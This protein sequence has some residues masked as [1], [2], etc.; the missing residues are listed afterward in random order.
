MSSYNKTLFIVE[1]VYGENSTEV[2]W[3]NIKL[4]CQVL[5]IVDSVG[6]IDLGIAEVF[7]QQLKTF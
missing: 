4:N 7:D 6:K 2:F 1:N 3:Y 5:I